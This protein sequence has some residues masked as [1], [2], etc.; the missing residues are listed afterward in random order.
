MNNNHNNEQINAFQ[1]TS[2]SMITLASAMAVAKKESE[3]QIN[4]LT[5]KIDHLATLVE[6]L[7]SKKIAQEKENNPDKRISNCDKCDKRH[8][9]GMCREEE[10]NAANSP[11][12]WKPTKK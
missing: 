1:E 6:K 11:H 12:Y 7:L 5:S 10:T 9:K 3:E 8:G 2:A 4:K